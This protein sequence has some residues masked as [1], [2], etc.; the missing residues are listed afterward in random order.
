MRYIVYTLLMVLFSHA[1]DTAFVTEQKQSLL[2]KEIILEEESIAKAFEQYIIDERKIPTYSELKTSSY[3]GSSFP[4][5][6]LDTNTITISITAF[7]NRLTNRLSDSGLSAEP[8]FQKIYLSDLY[9]KRTH[10]IYHDNEDD[11]IGL[12][13][14]DSF[15]KH[16]YYMIVSSNKQIIDGCGTT[17]ISPYCIE[18]NHLFVYSDTSRTGDLLMYYHVDKFRTGPIIITSDTSLHIT[19][20]DEFSS[21]PTGALLYDTN[22]VKYLKTQTSIELLR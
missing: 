9:R 17:G 8:N 20:S 6:L 13:L 12:I 5:T 10:I 19:R 14:E 16:I 11:E 2:I 22:G 1:A 3:L 7:S 21:I 18:S 4:T 15:A